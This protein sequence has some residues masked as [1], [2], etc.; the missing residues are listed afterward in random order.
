MTL[1][2]DGD[3]PLMISASIENYKLADLLFRYR[4]N[5]DK[6]NKVKVLP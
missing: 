5:V 6:A 3:T 1:Q 4:V 2:E